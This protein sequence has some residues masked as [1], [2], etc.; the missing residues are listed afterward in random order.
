MK[1]TALAMILLASVTCAPAAFARKKN[2]D[3]ARTPRPAQKSVKHSDRTL[4][5][6]QMELTRQ[7]VNSTARPRGMRT[8]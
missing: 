7:Q 4:G 3:A 5:D 8:Y 1:R 6:A 2:H